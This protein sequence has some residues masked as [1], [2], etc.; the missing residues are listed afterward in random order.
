MAVRP[1]ATPTEVKDYSEY[2]SVQNRPNAKVEIDI[3]RA[4]ADIIEY[5]GS[6]FSD[7]EKYPT[8]PDDIN[9]ATIIV[10][11]AYALRAK[12][13]GRAQGLKSEKFDDYSYTRFDANIAESLGVSALLNPYI[14]TTG[15]TG[16]KVFM[17]MRK[18]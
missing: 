1:W 6:D 16:N 10:A 2:S 3:R 4:E 14:D 7:N 15:S 18:L 11:E 12:D 13:Q 17:R 8:I 5:T 9:L